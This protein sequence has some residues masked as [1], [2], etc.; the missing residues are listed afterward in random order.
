M[1][2]LHIFIAHFVVAFQRG[3][4][5]RKFMSDEASGIVYTDCALL[6]EGSRYDAQGV[7]KCGPLGSTSF[8]YGI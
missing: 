1:F 7:G 6:P 2:F 4:G 8:A 5:V 3:N